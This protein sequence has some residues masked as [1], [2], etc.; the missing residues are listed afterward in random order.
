MALTVSIT[1][2]TYSL[3]CMWLRLHFMPIQ[4]H[5]IA[6]DLFTHVM[7]VLKQQGWSWFK[8][9]RNKD[10]LMSWNI[11]LQVYMTQK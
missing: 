4:V 9:I 6:N 7:V 8:Y 2:Y 11:L 5:C 1:I 3:I 10:V